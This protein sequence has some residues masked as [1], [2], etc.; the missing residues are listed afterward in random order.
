MTLYL[1]NAASVKAPGHAGR[2]DRVWLA[3]AAPQGWM[4]CLSLGTCPAGAPRL[5]WLRAVQSGARDPEDYLR[6]CAE[7]FSDRAED[8]LLA[9]GLLTG[10]LWSG[11]ASLVRDGDTLVCTCARPD[12]PRRTHRCHLE[13]LAPALVAA[14]WRVVLY[15]REIPPSTKKE[16]ICAE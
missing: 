1:T 5:D 6:D 2:T 9:P 8:G 7:L 3:M 10:A 13:E 16:V 11:C 4:R 15:G 12:S 14:G